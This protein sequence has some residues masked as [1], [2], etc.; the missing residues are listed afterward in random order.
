MWRLALLAAAAEAGVRLTGFNGGSCQES[1]MSWGDSGITGMSNPQ[2]A[3]DG[4]CVA[5]YMDGKARSMRVACLDSARVSLEMFEDDGC[6]DRYLEQTYD[7]DQCTRFDYGWFIWYEDY[8]IRWE[9]VDDCEVDAELCES[10]APSV[11]FSPTVVPSSSPTYIPTTPPSPEPSLPP[12]PAPSPAPTVSPSPAPS[13]PPSPA[14]STAAPSASPTP[15]PSGPPRDS[16]DDEL[17]PG[18]ASANF[19]IVI[20]V[21]G[22]LLL[23]AA[24]AARRRMVRKRP[25]RALPASRRSSPLFMEEIGSFEESKYGDDDDVQIPEGVVLEIESPKY[26]RKVAAEEG[27]MSRARRVSREGLQAV[28]DALR[29]RPDDEP[30]ALELTTASVTHAAD[31]VAADDVAHEHTDLVVDDDVVEASP[32]E[33]RAVDD[34]CKAADPVV[35]AAAAVAA[36]PARRQSAVRFCSHCGAAYGDAK[37]DRCPSCG[38]PRPVEAAPAEPYL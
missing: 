27:V 9:C 23:L 16:D 15:A 28:A 5:L 14:P 30:A 1:T 13:P 8:A 24:L 10:A 37:G 29:G 17:I 20:A 6:D 4:Q 7:D 22:A 33:A 31:L 32:V 12:S 34:E 26:A 11:N 3:V 18:V 19:Y 21:V 25:G 38:T 2:L 35:A 36:A